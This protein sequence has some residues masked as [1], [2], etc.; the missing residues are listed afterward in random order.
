[1]PLDKLSHQFS[2]KNDKPTLSYVEA[3]KESFF[4]VWFNKFLWLWGIFLPTGLYLNMYSL[5]TAPNEQG[6]SQ[7]MGNF[8][9]LK[10]FLQEQA[11][12][13]GIEN[14]TEKLG[15]LFIGLGIFFIVLWILSAISRAGAI[16]ALDQLQ[17]NKRNKDF[18]LGFVWRN[19]KKGLGKIIVLD[20]IIFFTL[21]VIIFFLMTPLVLLAGKTNATLLAF[22]STVAFIIYTPLLFLAIFIRNIGVIHITLA[23]QKISQAV[24]VSYIQLMNNLGQAAKLV[25]VSL[26]LDIL[27]SVVTL[28]VSIFIFVVLTG[29]AVVFKLVGYDFL[30]KE[31]TNSFL[32]ALLIFISLYLWIRAIFSLWSLDFWLWWAKKFGGLKIPETA[33]TETKSVLVE[34]TEPI[35]GIGS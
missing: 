14:W 13:Y 5:D 9:Q 33:Q 31:L 30:S 29:L 32:V 34:K 22:L 23:N 28:S 25:L 1:M 10:N 21:L 7:L 2:D 35:T 19:G 17:N 24:D 6:Q 20:A 15:Y 18:T 4:R 12:A 8:Q 11:T 27:Q 3:A 16:R 26:L